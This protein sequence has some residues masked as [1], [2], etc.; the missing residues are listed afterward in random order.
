[1]T[2]V[3]S[4]TPPRA[5]KLASYLC[6]Q[7][8]ATSAA[9]PTCGQLPFSQSSCQ[10]T[11]ITGEGVPGRPSMLPSVPPQRRR[12]PVANPAQDRQGDAAV[13]S[14]RR[15]PHVQNA[16]LRAT[17]SLRADRLVRYPMVLV[18]EYETLHVTVSRRFL[19]PRA[20]HGTAGPAHCGNCDGVLTWGGACCDPPWSSDAR[21]Q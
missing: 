15:T 16:H 9:T 12:A 5:T 4:S 13:T 14:A 2:P 18:Y 17:A 8:P 1:M 7:I 20:R 11:A 6:A 19:W 3:S 10:R 21:C